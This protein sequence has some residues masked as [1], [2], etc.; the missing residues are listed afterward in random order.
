M[1]YIAERH[2][3]VSFLSP[4]DKAYAKS[5]ALK[6]ELVFME[7]RE[8][9]KSKT[10]KLVIWANPKELRLQDLSNKTSK[11]FYLDFINFRKI[12]SENTLLRKCFSSKDTGSTV[13]DLTAGFCIDAFSMA[14]MGFEVKAMEKISWLYQLTEQ[15]LERARKDE[16]LDIFANKIFLEHKDSLTQ[17]KRSKKVEIAYIDPMFNS[18]DGSRAKKEIQFLRNLEIQDEAIEVYIDFCLKQNFKKIIVKSGL[19]S[20]KEKSLPLKPSNIIRG[21]ALKYLIFQIPG[22]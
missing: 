20:N 4:R 15:G 12:F 2:P 10:H 21:R 19:N 9:R 11:P 14:V 6:H 17:T 7:P 22:Q 13:I 18:N 16:R 1:N 3:F 8:I 5:F